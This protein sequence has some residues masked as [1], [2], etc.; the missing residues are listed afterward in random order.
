[1]KTEM[2]FAMLTIGSA[3]F[4]SRASAFDG[5]KPIDIAHA[6]GGLAPG[7]TAA[8]MH[9]WADEPAA[10]LRLELIKASRWLPGYNRSEIWRK[11]PK[12]TFERMCELV[13]M[14]LI[15]TNICQKC[16]GRRLSGSEYTEYW[17]RGDS[18]PTKCEKCHGSGRLKAVCSDFAEFMGLQPLEWRSIEGHYSEMYKLLNE[19]LYDAQRHVQRKLV[20]E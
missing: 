3:P 1:M 20:D 7:P 14:D 11:L 17:G 5:L 2:A 12:G 4:D 10:K 15:G 18:K 13:I 6:L 16:G 8:G 19:W 9:A